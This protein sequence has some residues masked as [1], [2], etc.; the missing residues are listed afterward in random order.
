LPRQ[1]GIEIYALFL[2]S[3]N[4]SDIANQ[5][6]DPDQRRI[7]QLENAQKYNLNTADIVRNTMK[8]T[9]RKT[10]SMMED[11]Y[12]EPG[13]PVLAVALNDPL[14]PLDELQIRAIEWVLISG[15]DELTLDCLANGNVIFRRFLCN[16]HDEIN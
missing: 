2:S 6:I 13:Q 4:L 8:I 16:P 10:Q 7:R 5:G 15:S 1:D 3:S 14:I 9:L 11:L 12:A